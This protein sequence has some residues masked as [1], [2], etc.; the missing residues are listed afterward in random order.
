M[1]LRRGERADR[2]VVGDHLAEA[3]RRRI[4]LRAARRASRARRRPSLPSPLLR[5]GVTKWPFLSGT[6]ALIASSTVAA[7]LELDGVRAREELPSASTCAGRELDRAR[8]SRPCG[9]ALRDPRRAA[10]APP[11]SIG[12]ARRRGASAGLSAFCAASASPSRRSDRD[13]SRRQGRAQRTHSPGLAESASSAQV[14]ADQRAIPLNEFDRDRSRS[15]GVD[16]LDEPQADR[17]RA[18]R[19][20]SPPGEVQVVVVLDLGARDDLVDHGSSPPSR[21]YWK[22]TVTTV[23]SG[24]A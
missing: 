13:G 20:R 22:W 21:T 6:C 17:A 1:S 11:A 14:A 23:P 5:S 19:H 3:G 15:P 24:G 12:L 16:E 2:G 18:R 9:R 10:P 7:I 4:E 8:R